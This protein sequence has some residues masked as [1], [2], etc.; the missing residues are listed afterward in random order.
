MKEA[1]NNFLK[2]VPVAADVVI[3]DTWAEKWRQL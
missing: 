2:K 3:A 1:G